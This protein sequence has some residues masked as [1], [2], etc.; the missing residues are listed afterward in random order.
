[1]QSFKGP[2]KK[3]KPVKPSAALQGKAHYHATSCAKATKENHRLPS[4][5]NRNP[6][7]AGLI[8]VIPCP[9]PETPFTAG[10]IVITI[11]TPGGIR[12]TGACSL[13]CDKLLAAFAV[14]GV[15][16]S[17]NGLAPPLGVGG[18][19]VK[20]NGVGF[21]QDEASACAELE[22]EAAV[23]NP[24]PGGGYVSFG[25]A[26]SLSCGRD[27]GVGLLTPRTSGLC[28]GALLSPCV[29]GCPE[30]MGGFPHTA[31]RGIQEC[32]QRNLDGA[33]PGQ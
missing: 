3:L 23:S 7:A 27:R 10:T 5:S 26:F 4:G 31:I 15:S 2:S 9:T 12:A 29:Q 28:S 32:H 8:T 24:C 1:M 21:D 11:P 22:L 16:G 33:L 19:G 6:T 25:F 13:W 30:P 17:K 18:S 14:G 20:R